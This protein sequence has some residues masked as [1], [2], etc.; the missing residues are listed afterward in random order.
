M[1]WRAILPTLVA[2]LLEFIGVS[3]A[4][5]WST[6]LSYAHDGLMTEM[7]HKQT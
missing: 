1:D 3:F 2:T 6:Q 4:P 7:G 5:L